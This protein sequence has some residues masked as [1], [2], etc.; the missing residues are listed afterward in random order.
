MKKISTTNYFILTLLCLLFVLYVIIQ[1][2]NADKEGFDVQEVENK[3]NLAFKDIGFP[4]AD[5]Y[6]NISLKDIRSFFNKVVRGFND[7]VVAPVEKFIDDARDKLNL[8]KTR[9]NTIKKG[10]DTIFSGIGHEFVALGDGMKTGF[11]D[12]GLLLIFL[13]E[14]VKTFAD[15]G[16]HY[17]VNFK[18]C[19]PFYIIDKIVSSIINFIIYLLNLPGVL[20]AQANNKPAL[21]TIPTKSSYIPWSETILNDCYICPRL[22][23]D[24]L[25]LKA[26][27]VD[28]DFKIKLPRRFDKATEEI[29]DGGRV[30][31]SAFSNNPLA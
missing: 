19:F 17:I 30:F 18:K 3:I 14:Y 15:C 5:K 8:V 2:V 27:Q 1:F 10:M 25:K 23:T 29:K 28:D 26:K 22:K 7:D 31:L 9:M 12:I 21:Y 6:V 13:W 16:K 11:D 20:Y 4:I 24:A